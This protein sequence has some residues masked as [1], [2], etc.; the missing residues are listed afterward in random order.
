MINNQ[1][2]SIT[3]NTTYLKTYALT[4]DMNNYDTFT[5]DM[6]SYSSNNV[7][8]VMYYLWCSYTQCYIASFTINTIIATHS[9]ITINPA[10]LVNIKNPI[11]SLHF[12]LFVLNEVTGLINEVTPADLGYINI[13]L[14][15][16]KY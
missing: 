11:N 7:T 16:T 9:V 8:D 15:F 5:I 10:V 6:I 4:T 14:S 13:I 12:T 3:G 1:I 2:V